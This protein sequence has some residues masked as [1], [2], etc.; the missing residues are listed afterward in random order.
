ME[1]GNKNYESTKSESVKKE[2]RE[3]AKENPL[4]RMYS[5][6]KPIETWEEFN[7]FKKDMKFKIAQEVEKVEKKGA[8][9]V[10]VISD[11][12]GVSLQKFEEIK[13]KRDPEILEIK[14]ESM[15]LG[16]RAQKVV[17]DLSEEI[18]K[19]MDRGEL[20]EEMT[21]QKKDIQI[22][23]NGKIKKIQEIYKE[24]IVKIEEIKQKIDR[25]LSD[26][27][28]EL[29]QAGIKEVQERISEI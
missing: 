27:E 2:S 11:S 20:L 13:L 15:E 10:R 6:R 19:M 17:D 18:K 24:F 7:E 12:L 1:Q 23:I 4:D 28:F 8:E 9:D 29:R 16:E 26:M 3:A 21:Q 14:I 22:E 5:E 25:V